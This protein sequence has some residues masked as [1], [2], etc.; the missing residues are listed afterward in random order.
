MKLPRSTKPKDHDFVDF[1]S[2]GPPAIKDG[3]FTETKIADFGCFSQ[4]GVSSNKYYSA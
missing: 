1:E 3:E 4:D 2:F